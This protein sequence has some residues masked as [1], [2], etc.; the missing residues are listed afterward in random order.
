MSTRIFLIRHGETEWNRGSIFQGH[1]DS[2]LTE[3][4]INQARALANRFINIQL[5]AAYSSD[6]S[7]ARHTAELI[8]NG[9]KHVPQEDARLRERG[10]GIFEGSRREDIEQRYPQEFQKYASG[11]PEYV[12]PGGESARGRFEMALGCLE[13]IGRKHEGHNVLVI[14]HG[15]VLT[16]MFRY[17]TGLGHL[18]KRKYSLY[19]CAFNSFIFT[20][21]N[22]WL[23]E[24]WGDL[25]HIPEPVAKREPGEAPAETSSEFQFTP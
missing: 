5:A 18:A 2:R 11:D 1:K 12:V 13:E 9:A 10:L 20:S 24:T 4:G 3:K 7:R 16:A 25:G 22:E 14:T 23:L 6:L 21:P 17:V 8:L 15:G 19:N